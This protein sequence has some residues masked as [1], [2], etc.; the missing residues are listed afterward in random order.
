VVAWAGGLLQKRSNGERRGVICR[1]SAKPSGAAR[2]PID[3]FAKKRLGKG[4]TKNAGAGPVDLHGL[5]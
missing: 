4:K 5:Q 2:G 3:Y 1:R